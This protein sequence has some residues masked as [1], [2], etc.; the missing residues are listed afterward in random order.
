MKILMTLLLVLLLAAM[1]FAGTRTMTTSGTMM[2]AGSHMQMEQS[3]GTC[4]MGDD[5]MEGCDMDG[6]D[7]SDCP[8]EGMDD[9]MNDC[10]GDGGMMGLFAPSAWGFQFHLFLASLGIL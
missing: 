1:P 8:M 7:M 10:H 6:T 9:M 4:P 3:D 2:M 5:D